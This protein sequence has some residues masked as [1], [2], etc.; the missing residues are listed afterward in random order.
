MQLTSLVILSSTYYFSSPHHCLL[1]NYYNLWDTSMPLKLSHIQSVLYIATFSSILF[2]RVVFLKYKSDHFIFLIKLFKSLVL[3][4]AY[5]TI[6]NWPLGH[7]SILTFYHTVFT[8]YSRCNE[9]WAVFQN[10]H[11]LVSGSLHVLCKLPDLSPVLSH[12][13]LPNICSSYLGL[14]ISFSGWFSHDC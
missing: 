11:T 14:D 5:I 7:L 6:Q 12:Y 4:K 13:S 10:N 2:L 1:L 3:R 8:S 9:L